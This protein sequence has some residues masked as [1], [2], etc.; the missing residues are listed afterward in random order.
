MATAVSPIKINFGT[1]LQ[2]MLKA[3]PFGNPP[4]EYRKIEDALSAQP[5]GNSIFGGIN[6]GH[7]IGGLF[8]LMGLGT[9]YLAYNAETGFQKAR[10]IYGSAF[11]L[12][13]GTVSLAI[14]I[15]SKDPALEEMKK[16]FSS[17]VNKLSSDSKDP[18]KKINVNFDDY[19]QSNKHID[20]FEALFSEIDNKGTTIN[21]M[22]EVGTGKTFGVSCLAGEI[23][24]RTGKVV[25][26]WEVDKE[27]TGSALGD[28]LSKLPFI[29]NM[30]GETRIQRLERVIANA[31]AEVK[32]SIGPDSIPKK[33]IIVSVDEVYD[34]LGKPTDSWDAR[35]FNPD[36][37]SKR[38]EISNALGVIYNK[39]LTQNGKGVTIAL[40]SNAINHDVSKHLK[41]R[42]IV[43]QEYRNPDPKLREEYYFKIVNKKLKEKG[44]KFQLSRSECKDLATVAGTSNLLFDIFG[45]RKVSFGD[46]SEE[47]KRVEDEVPYEYQRGGITEDEMR[48]YHLINF[49]NIYHQIVT[50]LLN[51]YAASKGSKEDFILDFRTKLLELHKSK[52]TVEKTWKSDLDRRA[53]VSRFI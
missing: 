18:S 43:N 33:H 42:F 32:K 25:E 8:T 40:M 6:F 41:D 51:E 14:G 50:P 10:F 49:R 22:G 21:L 28:A 31:M 7:I 45:K 53:K 27:A 16:L 9:S 17:Q 4:V 44:I 1:A 47:I 35:D 37:P 13:V 46:D 20:E 24:R 15:F 26:H 23:A 52:L 2:S 11:N 38:S 36:D 30:V 12:V 34:W 29:G 5:T 39:L 48:N 19:V 3:R